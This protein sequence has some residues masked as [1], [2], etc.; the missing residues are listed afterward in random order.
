MAAINLSPSQDALL[1]PYGRMRH[2]H[3][4]AFYGITPEKARLGVGR[5][6]INACEQAA[7][8]NGF[9]KM[10]MGATLPGVPFYAKMGYQELNKIDLPLPDG[11]IMC[12]TG[13]GKQLK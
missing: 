9:S 6:L 12:V 10:E 1:D 4:A 11:E 5:M 3:Q 7:I 8:D 2:T 13:M